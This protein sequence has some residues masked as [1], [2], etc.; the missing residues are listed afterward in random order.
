[1]NKQLETATSEEVKLQMKAQLLDHQACVAFAYD[2]DKNY[3]KESTDTLVLT[4]DLQQCLLTPYL[5][6]SIV[7]YIRQL[8]TYNLTIHDCGS[9]K[10]YCH[11]WDESISGRGANQIAAF[12]IF[13]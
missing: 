10:A 13:F 12:T 8:W 2:K 11:I 3:A 1:M 6:T 7:Y 4:F 5:K 9:N